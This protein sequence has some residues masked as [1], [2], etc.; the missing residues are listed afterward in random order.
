M[1]E[2]VFRVR[3][4][5]VGRGEDREKRN[6]IGERSGRMEKGFDFS[7]GLETSCFIE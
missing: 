5:K 2:G 3:A 4:G 1:R 6:G 7:G